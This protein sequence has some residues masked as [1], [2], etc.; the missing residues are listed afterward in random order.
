MTLPIDTTRRDSYRRAID[1]AI[2]KA[3]R[4][5]EPDD[6]I[7]HWFPLQLR[8]SRATEVR[9]Q[10]GLEAAQVSLGHAH[11]NVTEIYAEK[12]LELAMQVA[13]ATG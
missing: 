7:P 13:K 2:T 9:K 11:A 5:R 3:N 4:G 12:N 10:F 6:Q 1:Y 8:H